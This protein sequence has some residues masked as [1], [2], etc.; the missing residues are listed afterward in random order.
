M[1]IGGTKF[2]SART[3]LQTSSRAADGDGSREEKAENDRRANL[4]SSSFALI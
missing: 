1:G 4:S 2:E 3:A